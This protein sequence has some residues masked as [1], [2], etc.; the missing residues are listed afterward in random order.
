MPTEKFDQLSEYKRRR[1]LEAMWEEFLEIPYDEITVSRLTSRAGISRAST[2][3]YFS[4]KDDWFSAM[5]SWLREELEDWFCDCFV[6]EKGN[7]YQAMKEL[8]RRLAEEDEGRRLCLAWRRMMEQ[9]GCRSLILK[10]ESENYGQ[11]LLPR[12]EEACFQALD[13]AIYPA[14]TSQELISVINM[15]FMVISGG[16]LMKREEQNDQSQIL[17]QLAILDYGIRGGRE[18][19]TT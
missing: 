5:A 3:L 16:V 6:K 11:W 17:T 14:V 7:Y 18:V 4:G 9:P 15:G 12:H 1:I 10:R 8:C 13:R 2:Y 19:Q